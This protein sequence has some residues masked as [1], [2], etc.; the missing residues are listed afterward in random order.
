MNIRDFKNEFRLV[1]T[2]TWGNA[3]DAWFECAAHLNE[4]AYVP[5]EW[6]YKASIF[7]GKD[8]SSYWYEIF[9]ECDADELLDIGN[10]LFR[11]CQYLKFKEVNY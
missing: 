8:K 4:I 1:C 10:F 3:L 11:Y 7:G 6:E 5:I 2:D 9:D